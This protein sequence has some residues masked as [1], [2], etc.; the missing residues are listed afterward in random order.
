MALNALFG[1]ASGL[2]A[3]STVLDV[4]GQN[5]ANLSTTGFK[6]Q[7]A[8]FQDLVYQTLNAGSSPSG[9]SGGLNPTQAGSGVRVGG[10]TSLFTQGSVTPTGRAL[11]AA[12]QGPGFFV[13]SNSQSTVFSRGGAFSIDSAG[14]LVDP[15]TGFRVQRTGTVGEPTATSGGFQIIGN[16]DIKVPLGAGTPGSPTSNVSFQGNLSSGLL[17]GGSVTTSIQVFDTQ[18]T[19]RSL[20]V[21]FTKTG[22]NTFEASATIAGGTAT[23]ATNAVTFNTN[24][25]LN[26]PASLTVN[27]TGF[28]GVADFDIELDLGTIGQ[29]TGLSQFGG[30][31]TATAVTQDGTGFGT[32]T[33]VS[34]DQE[35]QLIGQFTNGK[36]IPL[37]QLAIAGFNNE[38]GLL[39][40]GDNY[41]A[42]SPASGEPIVGP[43]GAGGRGKVQ[44]SS[45]EGSNVDIATEFAQLIIAQRGF[46]VNAQTISVANETLQTLN[47]IIR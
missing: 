18:S 43:A 45:L 3:N 33:S 13:L 14:F 47:T 29:S 35:G 20:S 34:Y 16:Q 4:V 28:S 8:E 36:T 41:F 44:G 6:T 12:I 26:G 1:G 15:T 11:D 39:R 31:S 21:T 10:I 37:A 42:T 22:V 2:A 23:I 46:Q 24:G 30:D 40:Q 7:R 17:V 32:L 5:L 27:L 9:T 19:P 38:G 25:S